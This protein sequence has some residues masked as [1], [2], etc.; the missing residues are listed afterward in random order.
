MPK[1]SAKQKNQTM[2]IVLEWVGKCSYGA[3]PVRQVQDHR[4]LMRLQGGIVKIRVA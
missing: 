1:E 4:Y 2:R 3:R